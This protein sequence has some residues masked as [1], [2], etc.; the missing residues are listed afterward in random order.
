MLST[1]V[2]HVLSMFMTLGS[3][4]EREG[5]GERKGE[6]EQNRTISLIQGY[7]HPFIYCLWLPLCGRTE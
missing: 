4:K 1:D 6:R 7:V 2:E 5:D 3:L